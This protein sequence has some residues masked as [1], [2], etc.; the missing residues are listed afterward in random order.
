[1]AV[2]LAATVAAAQLT[3]FTATGHNHFGPAPSLVPAAS[4][5]V[6]AA[7]LPLTASRATFVMA[8]TPQVQLNAQQWYLALT[9]RW[10]RE[11]NDEATHAFYDSGST[12]AAIGALLGTDPTAVVLVDPAQQAVVQAGVPQDRRSRVLPW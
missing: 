8:N 1:M 7:D 10:T 9:G 6:A 12:M 5:I 11:A 4:S 2:P 3:G